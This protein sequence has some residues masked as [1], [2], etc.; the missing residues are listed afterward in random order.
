MTVLVVDDNPAVR[1]GLVTLLEEADGITVTGT[2]ADGAEAVRLVEQRGP[3]VTL[4]DVRMPVM[5]GVAAAA[6]VGG[7][8]RVVMLTSASDVPTVQRA[9]GTGIAG[10]LVHGA[11]RPEDLAQMVRDVAAGGAHLSPYAAAVAL[12]EAAGPGAHQRALCERRGISAREEDVLDLMAAGAS[13][14]DIAARLFLSPK[15]VKNHVN[16]IFTKIDARDR[17]QAIATWLGTAARHDR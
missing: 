15:T 7:R 11:F 8:T 12:A 14:A 2:A 10:Y 9:L 1:A 13:N 6:V 4:L 16:R 3:D 17:G 5:D